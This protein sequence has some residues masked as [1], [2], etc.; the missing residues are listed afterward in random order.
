M[1]CV[2]FHFQ[3]LPLSLMRVNNST[4]FGLQNL[5]MMC[6]V[7]V[8]INISITC[9]MNGSFHSKRNDAVDKESGREQ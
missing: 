1:M 3:T 2:H 6:N 9:E 4:L 7:V 5:I 8:R